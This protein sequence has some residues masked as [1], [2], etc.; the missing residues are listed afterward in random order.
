MVNLSFANAALEKILYNIFN[1]G[2][3]SRFKSL[4]LSLPHLPLYFVVKSLNTLFLNIFKFVQRVCLDSEQTLFRSL[5]KIIYINSITFV[6][7]LCSVILVKENYIKIKFVW[8]KL[9]ISSKINHAVC[10]YK[11]A[12][13]GKRS[14]SALYYFIIV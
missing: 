10:M 12:V 5:Q 6:L 14:L 7:L 8:I 1:H 13:F 11:K 9:V 4:T 2:W 3:V